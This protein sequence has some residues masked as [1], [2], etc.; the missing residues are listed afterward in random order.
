ME[1]FSTF[2]VIL[3][4]FGIPIWAHKL[5]RRWWVWALVSFFLG[6]FALLVLWIKETRKKRKASRKV[7]KSTEIV[8]DELVKEVESSFPSMFVQPK[9]Q[10]VVNKDEGIGISKSGQ[11]IGWVYVLTNPM[12][13]GLTKIG[14]TIKT[15]EER[16]DQLDSTGLP[17]PFIEHYRVRCANPKDVESRLHKHFASKRYKE[18]REF[19]EIEPQD[20]YEVLRDWGVEDLEI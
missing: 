9:E 17:E 4:W 6:P 20:V 1:N 5:Q 2:L 3:S 18:N 15:V 11:Q 10:I 13:P 12:F 7:L 14:F 16:M 8:S 19:F